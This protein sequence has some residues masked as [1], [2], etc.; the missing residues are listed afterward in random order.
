MKINLLLINQKFNID[1][2][3][4]ARSKIQV[5]D[6]VPAVHGSFLHTGNKLFEV[7]H[8]FLS[9][10]SLVDPNQFWIFY[11]LAGF[12]ALFAFIK[13]YS[14]RDQKPL[15]S[16]WGKSPVKQDGD[17]RGKV[18]FIVAVF[19][20]LNFLLSIGLLVVAVNQKF[21]IFPALQIPVFNVFVLA[22]LAT[23]GYYLVNVISILV[24]SF[25]FGVSEQAG[26]YAKT[27]SRLV[28]NLGIVLLPLLLFYFFTA[29]DI[30]LYLS[31]G[32][33]VVFVLFKWITLLRM[34]DSVDHYTIFH[35]IL[36]LCAL[37]IIP[38]MLLIK[39]SMG[40]I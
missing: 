23:L 15:Y 33:V 35:N 14:F 4:I 38:I 1:S 11:L 12:L 2:L 26:W 8:P 18:S 13:Y 21:H 29:W 39:V 22:V 5:H 16:L 34:G 10:N 19:L 32:V 25:L 37:E 3:V 17:N 9:G 20:F 6:T 36:Y 28:F 7:P 31:V 24:V 27:G 30:L 40:N